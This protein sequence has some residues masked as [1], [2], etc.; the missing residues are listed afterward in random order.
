MNY[1][2][3]YLKYK[4]KYFELKKIQS[5]GDCYPTPNPDD[6]EAIS[7][8]EYKNIPPARLIS[9]GL[10]PNRHCFD[11]EQLAQLIRLSDNPT[12]PLTREVFGP[13][14][15][16]K[17]I[18]SYNNYVDSTNPQLTLE[19]NR[20]NYTQEQ[21]NQIDDAID[22]FADND[23]PIPQNVIELINNI[24]SGN[25]NLVDQEPISNSNAN[26][27]NEFVPGTI[28][29]FINNRGDIGRTLPYIDTQNGVPRFG[30][31]GRIVLMPFDS[32]MN[33]NLFFNNTPTPNQRLPVRLRP[34]QLVPG[35]SY[36]E[37]RPYY[38][39]DGRILQLKRLEPFS[40][41]YNDEY[42]EQFGDNVGLFGDNDIPHSLD[43]LYSEPELNR[44]GI[45][46]NN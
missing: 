30:T 6:N 42:T 4:Y 45:F 37:P 2:Q 39:D 11:V 27:V 10:P 43:M 32:P 9:I 19:P 40:G 23:I 12:N 20:F 1:Y 22:D 7:L 13:Y 31:N 8:N 18:L 21:L 26:T 44:I 35:E 15:L 14:E 24:K 36:I 34:Q 46:L 25:N 29:I 17:I 38:T 5:G 3:K 16:W 41:L 33:Q 28:Y